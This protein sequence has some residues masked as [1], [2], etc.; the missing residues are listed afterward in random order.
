MRVRR[1]NFADI[2]LIECSDVKFGFSGSKST[3][4]HSLLLRHLE[5]QN[6]LVYCASR[7]A[8]E[9]PMLFHRE[10]YKRQHWAFPGIFLF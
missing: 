1:R 6:M 7:R 10:K 5:E 8:T 4:Y 2:Q 9:Q 3:Q